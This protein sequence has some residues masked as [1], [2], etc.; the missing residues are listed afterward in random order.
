MESLFGISTPVDIEVL[1]QDEEQRKHI[2]TRVEKD[3][4]ERYP[5]YLDGENVVG[6]IIVKLRGGKKIEHY[7]IRVEFIGSIDLFCEKSK[8][9]QFLSLSQEVASPGELVKTTTFDF[10]FKNVEKQYEC[11]NGINVRLRYFVCIRIARRLADIVRER[12]IWVN[13]YKMPI[14]VNNSTKMEVGIEDCLHIDFEYNK[15]KYHLKDVIVGKI[16]FLLV[17]IKIK[18]MELSIIRRETTGSPPNLYN[19]S[20]NI[21]KFEIMDGAPVKGETIPI[22]LFLGGFELGPTFRDINKKFS[23]SK[24]AQLDLYNKHG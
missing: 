1:F 2:D 23:I 12:D 4:R 9:F 14:E 10:E 17:R 22:R 20:E 11:Y 15:S 24:V 8:S 6:K 18:T 7:G 5:I 16:Y 3:R 21:T 19:E 13:S